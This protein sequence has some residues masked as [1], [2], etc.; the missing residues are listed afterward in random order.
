M[1]MMEE[2]VGGGVVKKEMEEKSV[3]AEEVEE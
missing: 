3:E 2:K 1:E